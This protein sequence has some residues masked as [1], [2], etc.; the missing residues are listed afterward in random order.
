MTATGL[1]LSGCGFESSCSHLIFR[2]FVFKFKVGCFFLS[3]VPE[4]LKMNLIFFWLL[5]IHPLVSR[6]ACTLYKNICKFSCSFKNFL[7]Y[8]YVNNINRTY[9]FIFENLV[10]RNGR[11]YSTLSICQWHTFLRILSVSLLDILQEV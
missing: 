4:G 2:H 7:L 9:S 8:T 1:E 6:K 10:F 5:L 3:N 11:M